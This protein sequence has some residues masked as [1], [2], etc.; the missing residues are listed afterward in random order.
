MNTRS[1]PLSRAKKLH[2]GMTMTLN[3]AEIGFFSITTFVLDNRSLFAKWYA[4]F[5]ATLK[6]L[7]GLAPD[8]GS[9][10]SGTVVW[11][12][13][14]SS[15]TGPD[16]LRLSEAPTA[17]TNSPKRRSTSRGTYRH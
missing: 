17:H 7:F 12:P 1:V 11:I 2:S 5:R 6:G 15:G 14:R 10:S 8:G 13:L 4:D 16:E 3:A 9:V